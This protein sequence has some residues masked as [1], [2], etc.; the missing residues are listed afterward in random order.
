V[1]R[2]R[3]KMRIPTSERRVKSGRRRVPFSP[4]RHL[5]IPLPHRE[6]RRES[7]AVPG[8]IAQRKCRG[9]AE[10]AVKVREAPASADAS[11][12]IT[13]PA[14]TA[15][16]HFWTEPYCWLRSSAVKAEPVP[17]PAI[18]RH[19]V[20]PMQLTKKSYVRLGLGRHCRSNRLFANRKQQNRYGA[21]AQR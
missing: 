16:V 20:L 11:R 12:P 2:R 10:R 6:I 1:C 3:L 19:E 17:N 14:T 8:A 4:M 9:G 15:C 13:A 7:V 18:V 5:I 21:D